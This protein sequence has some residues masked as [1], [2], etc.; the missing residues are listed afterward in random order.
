MSARYS[1]AAQA[2]GDRSSAAAFPCL[3]GT[4]PGRPSAWLPADGAPRT[5]GPAALQVDLKFKQHKMD[6]DADLRI[7][8]VPRT[9]VPARPGTARV[10]ASCWVL[11]DV[12]ATGSARLARA[13]ALRPLRARRDNAAGGVVRPRSPRARPPKT[14]ER[15]GRSPRTLRGLRPPPPPPTPPP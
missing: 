6:R 13:A 11:G 1:R 15:E 10:R 3:A 5:R 12:R 2:P 4:A 9:A 8:E 14:R 7:R